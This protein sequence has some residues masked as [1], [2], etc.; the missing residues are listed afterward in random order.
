MSEP[1]SALGGAKTQALVTV[2]EMAPRGMIVLR[3]KLDDAA[4]T[5]V[6][7]KVSGLA[8]PGQRG[9]TVDG[10]RRLAW[11]SPDEAMLILP[12]GD[13]SGAQADLTAALAGAH[14]LVADLSDARAS[15]RISGEDAALR[16]VLARLSP[17]DM[18]ETA[19]GPGMVRRTRLAQ[20]AGAFWMPEAGVAE[21]VTF[22]SV[23]QY[24]FDLLSVAARSPR[25]FA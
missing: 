12:R 19:F 25:V 7:E 15:F 8:M 24:A 18:H 16:E 9:I 10:A 3:G 20:V 22:R 1:V 13:V 23:A 5:G 21:L 11:M 14:A 2:E 6:L 4:I 17:V